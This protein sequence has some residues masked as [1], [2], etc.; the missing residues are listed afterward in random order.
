MFALL[1]SYFGGGQQRAFHRDFRQLNFIAVAAAAF[2]SFFGL[3]FIIFY[4]MNLKSMR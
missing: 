1:R 3:L 2:V 4:A